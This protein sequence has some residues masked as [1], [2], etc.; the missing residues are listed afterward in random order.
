MTA[1]ALLEL[2]ELFDAAGLEVWLDG[3]W[4]VDALL[5][6]QTRP[7][8][9]ADLVL[10]ATEL[11]RL[12][13]LLAERGFEVRPG[14]T[15]SNF[16]LANPRGLEV[17][18]HAI[19]FDR[20]GNG[21][22]RMENGED[23]I[24]PA[25]GFR[26]RGAVAGRRV[27]CLS[28]ETQVLCHAH[29]YV[30][31]E[32]DFRDMELLR[33]RFGVELPPQLRRG[34]AGP[35]LSS[36]PEGRAVPDRATLYERLGGYDAIAAVADDLLSRLKADPRLARFWQHRGEDG[37]RREK[38]LLIDF[39]CASA[40]GPLYYTGRDMKTVHRGM[41]IDE[42]DWSAF[43][44]HL[45]ATLEKFQ[46]PPPERDAVAAFVQGTKADIVEGPAARGR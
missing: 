8:K 11:A 23:W 31:T 3:G 44:G 29:G 32:K 22:Y 27:R 36:R 24:F 39:L 13:A 26:G 9:D 7:H 30:P 10:P 21:V 43:L 42:G 2:L 45:D 18:V 4:G 20:A 46:V 33:H 37:V 6:V 28:A 15:P 35:P 41:G 12:R 38:Q 16:V 19:R 14:G 5:G 17:D 25:E 1:A 34:P 40:G